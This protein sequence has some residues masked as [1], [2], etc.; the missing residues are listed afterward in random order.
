MK[1][2]ASKTGFGGGVS[3]DGRNREDCF[4]M[5]AKVYGSN[6]EGGVVEKRGVNEQGLG[7]FCNGRSNSM[8]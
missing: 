8:S 1:K 2:Q 5:Q 3:L 7:C 6:G 4:P